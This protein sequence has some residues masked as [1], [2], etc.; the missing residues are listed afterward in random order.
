MRPGIDRRF[1]LPLNL[2]FLTQRLWFL[3]FLCVIVHPITLS[4]SWAQSI[5]YD[6][7]LNMS[8]VNCT[9]TLPAG[10]I[11]YMASYS[12][13]YPNVTQLV[14]FKKN[15]YFSSD[16]GENK[17]I[18]Q[19]WTQ[20]F[21]IKIVKPFSYKYIGCIKAVV[22]LINDERCAFNPLSIKWI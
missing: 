1:L 6:Q 18:N 22:M 20:S 11:S 2:C 21:K 14:W 7:L 15:L 8:V 10:A 5:S 12:T 3:A 17:F 9:E 13:A 4:L 16:Y 19:N